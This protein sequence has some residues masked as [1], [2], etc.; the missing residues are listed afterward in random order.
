MSYANETPYETALSRA[1]SAENLQVLRT[2][3]L[4]KDD[5]AAF[6]LVHTHIQKQTLKYTD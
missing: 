5:R 2:L 6:N 4:L 1:S 3:K